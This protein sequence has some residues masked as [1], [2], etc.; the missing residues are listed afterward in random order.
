MCTPGPNVRAPRQRTRR[1]S[2][3]N[4]AETY[5]LGRLG[6]AHCLDVPPDGLMER[7]L[8]ICLYHAPPP[9]AVDLLERE[10]LQRGGDPL[11][12]RGRERDEVRVAVHEAHVPHVL[13]HLEDVSG[14]EH[15]AAL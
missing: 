15:A 4:R 10:R 11:H 14:E 3:N 5:L 8:R 1:T 9:G 12:A 6:A 13:R 7:A 2:C